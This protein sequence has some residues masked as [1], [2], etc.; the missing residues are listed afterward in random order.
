MGVRYLMH[1]KLGFLEK[2][3]E[4]RLIITGWLVYS[5]LRHSKKNL[6]G[7]IQL[8]MFSSYLHI[9]EFLFPAVWDDSGCM[10]SLVTLTARKMEPFAHS[11][12]DTNCYTEGTHRADRALSTCLHIPECLSPAA[13]EGPGWNSPAPGLQQQP[14]E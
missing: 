12:F 13:W 11:Q 6:S 8:I 2:M 4:K 14:A 5:R 3:N 9:E 1:T 7:F 10:L